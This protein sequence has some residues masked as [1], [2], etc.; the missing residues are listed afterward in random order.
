[1]PAPR[2]ST[3][4]R[5]PRKPAAS[6]RSAPPWLAKAPADLLRDWFISRGWSPFQFQE[7][8]WS[9]F[10]RGDSG[11]INVPTGAGK[12][13]AAYLGPL[14]D[15][16]AELQNIRST[17]GADGNP[18][19]PPSR[20]SRSKKLADLGLRILFITPLRAVSRDTELALRAPAETLKLPIRVESRTGD[21]SAS[22]RARQKKL[23]PEVLITTPESLCLIL[24]QDNA[25]D[26]VRGLRAVICDEWHELLSSKRGTQ[27]E[28]ALAR[29]RRLAPDLR[30]WGLSATLANL[31]EAASA[32]VGAP[33]PRRPAA[34]PLPTIIRARIDR[35]LIIE[36]VIPE[37]PRRLPWAGHMGMR[38]LPDC[39]RVLDPNRSTLI[40]CNTRAQ[41]EL[42]YQAIRFSRPEWA[43]VMALHHGSIERTQRE[44]VER[45]LKTG[46]IRLVVCTSSLDLGVDFAP[47]E[48]VLQIGSP[49]GVAR[50]LQRAGRSGHRPGAEARILCIPTH[51][52]ELLEV[53]SVR[54]AISEGVIEPRVPLSKPLDV[55]AQHL[56]T[57][58]L[59]GGFDADQL[60][61]EVRTAW[62]Y[63]TL[64]RQEFDWALALVR[65]GGDTLRAYPMYH[66][67]QLV[68][69]ASGPPSGAG[70]LAGS[71]TD[72]GPPLYRVTNKRIAQLHRLNLG[73]ITAGGSVQLRYT[74]GR[75]IGAIDE[76]FITSLRPGEV[77]YF[78]G[79]TLQFVRIA[80][81]EAFVRPAR[82]RTTNT[83]HWSGT[84]LPISES[85]SDE[86]R[87]VL[88]DIAQ[89]PCNQEPC[90]QEPCN[91]EQRNRATNQQMDEATRAKDTAIP[92]S[93]TQNP[94]S[95]ISPEISAALPLLRTQQRLSALPRQ[96]Q[97]LC[98]LTQTRDGY[99]LFVFP[100][101]GR[102]VH[103]GL[104]S[105]LALRLSRLQPA[106]F[107]I[108]VSD[109]GFELLT[110]EPMPYQDLLTP[111][112][113]S[114][115]NLA[116]DA[117]ESVNI[118]AL[119][120]TQFREI[121]RVAGLVFQSYPGARKSGRQM[122]AS[123][124]LIYDV[125]AEFDPANLLLEQ[126]RREV[127]E[128]HFE[129]SRLARTLQRMAAAQLLF[130]TSDFP[131]P[132]AFPLLIERIGAKLSSESI[133]DRIDR[134]RRYWESPADTPPPTQD[135]QDPHS[136]NPRSKSQNPRSKIR[137]PRRFGSHNSGYRI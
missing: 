120:K 82:G 74:S 96:S 78:A 107:S 70:P 46:S 38:M 15:L 104:A 33:P 27:T 127:L 6:A 83:P 132:L 86:M 85:L 26:L 68:G 35:P 67:I 135:I 131:S 124:S 65:E 5:K 34:P 95:R 94:V 110:P 103:G 12:T 115:D 137:P 89:E 136:P 47:V 93:R 22:L 48:R 117:L 44:R 122:Q 32:V 10:A 30:T 43:D 7:E 106:T 62:S 87:K 123:S 105:L 99:H 69:R 51:A 129:Q 116:T 91:Q 45:G 58:A 128:R 49:K 20:P 77:F 29:L 114:T 57:C 21:T 133:A 88:G 19:P 75:P 56:V 92:R 59:G 80:D 111:S 23:L 36:S 98:E 54:R 112:L 39:L 108:A 79:K 100:F 71:P 14:A 31:D 121:A 118:S 1:M 53:E 25:A 2:T 72:D 97:V 76:P 50:L 28:L 64:T 16:I 9:A 63:R 42:W 61:E 52:M 11:L 18:P 73:T 113:F 37:D 4:A 134:I 60:F 119:A 102:L 109:Y 101:E 40:F 13:Y 3:K 17:P 8:A 84:K 90:N 55:L 81:L 125:F 126:A 130:T 66:K 24:A 41:A